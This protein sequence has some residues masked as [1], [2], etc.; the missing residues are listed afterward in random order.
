M[1][2]GRTPPLSRARTYWLGRSTPLGLLTVARIRKVPV[3]ALYDGS[4]KVILPLK[5]KTLSSGCTSSTVMFMSGG[6]F[7]R[8]SRMSFWMR[9]NSFSDR[10]KFTHIGDSTDTVVS[11]AFCGF[12]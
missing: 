8:P 1:A 12:R 11:C 2:F 7:R 4:A 10:L 6:S 5:G 3:C 9:R